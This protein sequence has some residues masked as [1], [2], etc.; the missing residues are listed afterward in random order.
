MS[1]PTVPPLREARRVRFGKGPALA[2]PDTLRR[3]YA[4][5]RVHS[6]RLAAVALRSAC[7]S[8]TRKGRPALFADSSP[9]S[10]EHRSLRRINTMLLINQI[11]APPHF[12]SFPRCDHRRF[13]AVRAQMRRVAQ[14]RDRVR[15]RLRSTFQSKSSRVDG[16]RAN[17]TLPTANQLLPLPSF[18]LTGL[19]AFHVQ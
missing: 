17:G 2:H 10:E 1:G 14:G 18:V 16:P 9:V 13:R 6:R 8:T 11:A 15:D 12:V 7:G 3:R 4:A 19:H 5:R